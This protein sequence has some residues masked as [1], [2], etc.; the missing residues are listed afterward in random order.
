MIV[1][2][3]SNYMIVYNKIKDLTILYME[4]IFVLDVNTGW[5]KPLIA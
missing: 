4:W 3:T 1:F 2:K 5:T